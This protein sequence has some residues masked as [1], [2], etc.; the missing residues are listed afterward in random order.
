M[1]YNG[2]C[3]KTFYES[4]E[5]TASYVPPNSLIFKTGSLCSLV[6]IHALKLLT[7]VFLPH[8][9]HWNIGTSTPAQHCT[10]SRTFWPAEGFL[11]RFGLGNQGG[12]LDRIDTSSPAQM[13]LL[14]SNLI[15]NI[16]PQSVGM[17]L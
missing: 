9:T 14:I 6:L 5:S 15:L 3:L 4:M 2:G 8:T 7:V 10:P 1:L 16:I 13:F 17:R 12:G 11:R